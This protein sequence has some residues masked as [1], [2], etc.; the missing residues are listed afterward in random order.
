MATKSLKKTNTKASTTA[1]EAEIQEVESP[2][3]KTVETAK[4]VAAA[5]S[6]TIKQL[7]D[8]T[9]K[10]TEKKVKTSEK[11]YEPTDTISCRSVFEGTLYM[12][13]KITKT[14]YTWAGYGDTQEIEFQDLRALL[15]ANSRYLTAPFIVIDDEELMKLPRWKDLQKIYDDLF[16]IDSLDGMFNSSPDNLRRTL[17]LLPAGMHA[18]VKAGAADRITR[19]MLDSLTKIKIIDEVL[20]TDLV[21]T[22]IK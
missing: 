22:F 17:E 20:G 15:R 21:A 5:V 18:S 2:E 4:V 16:S 3:D 9:P 1:K 13:G 14:L 8:D 11:D 6:E 19:G 7:K 10:P 12:G